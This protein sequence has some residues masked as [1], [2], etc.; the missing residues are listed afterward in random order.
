MYGMTTGSKRDTT[1]WSSRT[2]V[3]RG[4]FDWP[5]RF[6]SH[7]EITNAHHSALVSSYT[8]ADDSEGQSARATIP[9]PSNSETWPKGLPRGIGKRQK[10]A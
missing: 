7:P 4:R 9:P 10:Y 5:R 1:H 3:Q 8:L 2:M 6:H